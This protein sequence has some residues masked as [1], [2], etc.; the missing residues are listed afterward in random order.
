MFGESK[1]AVLI[2]NSIASVS[3]VGKINLID[4]INTIDTI[5][6]MKIT[7]TKT[8]WYFAV[9]GA[10]G[11]MIEG[12]VEFSRDMNGRKRASVYDY[13]GSKLLWST[14]GVRRMDQ[15]T[16]AMAFQVYTE[17]KAKHDR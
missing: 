3:T 5:N 11:Y 7:H 1:T 10:D 13:H 2:C 15:R 9:R 17:Q 4:G 16:A 12:C 14:T 8:R 6:R